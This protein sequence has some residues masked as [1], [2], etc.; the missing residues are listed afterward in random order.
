LGPVT[1]L[2]L[3]GSVITDKS[4][5]FSFRAETVAA[6]GR[7]VHSAGVKTIVVHGGGSFGHTLAK[8]FGLSSSS[9]SEDPVGVSETRAA[10][11]ELDRLVCKS[12]AESK[13]SPYPFSPFDLLT[14]TSAPSA[15]RWLAGLL[16]RGMTPVTFGDVTLHP[17]GFRVLSGDTIMFELS[18]VI[19]PARAVF[20]LDVDGVLRPGGNEIISRLSPRSAE[21][22]QLGGATDVT[23]GM[24]LKLRVA[25][26][27]ARAGVEVRFVS[28]FRRHEVSKAI[29][30]EDFYGTVLR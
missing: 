3:G 18:R 10:M 9:F 21:E 12:L 23:G 28:G 13:V 2:K 27:M 17:S 14:R 19:R 26:R 8:K 4:T 25:A 15:R 24:E 30:G 29:K 22:L 1:L 16:G 7:E 11:F 5:P 20:A 6:I